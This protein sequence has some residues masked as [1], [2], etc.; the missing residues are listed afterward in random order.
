MFLL[1][2]Y[3][4]KTCDCYFFIMKI[5]LLQ[6]FKKLRDASV[7]KMQLIDT[8]LKPINEKIKNMKSDM[9]KLRNTLDSHVSI[10]QK[11]ELPPE[12]FDHSTYKNCIKLFMYIFF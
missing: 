12:I 10:M 8:E 7:K 6:Q 2:L 3:Q 4:R 1:L 5:F 11:I 9:T